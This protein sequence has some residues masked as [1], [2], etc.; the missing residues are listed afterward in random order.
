M[1]KSNMHEC[2]N[3]ESQLSAYF[4]KQLPV[5]KRHLIKRHLNRCSHCKSQFLSIQRTDELLQFV[6]PVKASDTFLSDVLAQ[7]RSIDI[8]RDK[9]SY[10]NCVGSYVE[11]MQKWLRG[12]IKAYNPLFMIGFIFGV[13]IMIGATLYSPRIENFNLLPKFNTSSTEVKNNEFISFEV[14]TQQE[15]KRTLKSR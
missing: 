11:G 1:K 5:W 14:I 4:D 3:I 10:F 9:H 6:E 2:N 13:F 12:R 15:P 8:K 7:A